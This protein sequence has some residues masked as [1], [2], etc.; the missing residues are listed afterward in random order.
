MSEDRE[1]LQRLLQ[2]LFHART[3]VSRLDAVVLAEALDLGDTLVEIVTLLPPGT[4]TRD[5][6]ADQLNSIIT[7]HGW[8]RRFGTAE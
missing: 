6:L 2:T 8:S 7:G 3:R 4:Y 5:R 1:S